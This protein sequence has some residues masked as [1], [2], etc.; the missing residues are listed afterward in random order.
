MAL[1]T[2]AALT[3]IDSALAEYKQLRQSS[4]YDDCSDHGALLV[5]SMSTR[6]AST[7]ERYAPSGSRHIEGLRAIV[8]GWG[9]HI[10]SGLAPLAGVLTALRDD[11][12]AGRLATITELIHG[13]V[14]SDFL[15]MADHLLEEGYKDPAAVLAGGVLE[16]HLRK[17]C[18]KHGIASVGQNGKPKKS[19]TMNAE[20]AN[21][22]AYSKLDLKNV[23]AWLDLRNR[24]AHGDYAGYTKEQVAL[25]VQ[26][27]RDFITRHP[28]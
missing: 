13:D 16:E 11:I 24:A 21:A 9:P 28:A 25:L 19:D 27:I 26:S 23:L 6:L 12:A 1:D 8:E 4:K 3:D 7:I 2:T 22:N 14:F 15:D 5:S 17:L 10:A 20:L 18:A